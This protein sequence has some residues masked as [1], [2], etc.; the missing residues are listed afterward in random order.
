LDLIVFVVLSF[1]QFFQHFFSG[2]LSPLYHGQAGFLL[3][4]SS[5]L[6]ARVWGTKNEDCQLSCYGYL[7][8]ILTGL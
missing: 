6:L 4:F 7:S 2:S 5:A 1:F 8:G 3:I